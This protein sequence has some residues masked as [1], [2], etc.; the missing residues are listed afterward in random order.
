MLAGVSAMAMGIHLPS[1]PAI[2]HHFKV[3]ARLAQLTVAVF[4]WGNALLQIVIGPLSDRYGRRVILMWSSALFCLASLGCAYAPSI[5]VLLICR[6]AQAVIAGGLVLSRTIVRDMFAP[7]QA[8]SMIGYVTM[9]MA[10]VPM[11]APGLGGILQ[12]TFGWQGSFL[13]LF[14]AGALLFLLVWAD[15]GETN[16][17]NFSSFGAQFRAY[18]ELLSSWR[19]WGYAITAALS[20]GA[21]F[22]YLGGAPVVGADIFGMGPTTLGFALGAP[23]LGYIIGNWISGRYSVQ[24]GINRMVLIGTTLSALGLI[25]MAA[26]FMTGFG[27]VWVFFGLMPCVGLGNGMVIP[28][29]TSGMLS[30]RPHL[31]GTASGLGGALM[32][33]GG[34]AL[35]T[36]GAL[37]TST[38]ALPLILMMAAS[39]VLAVFVI[40][41]TLAREKKLATISKP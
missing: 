16:A 41:M 5:E 27:S 1:L 30:V 22:A 31:A 33:A 23:A 26:L 3:D 37:V 19:F 15:L 36:L 10:I 21:F 40:R 13:A 35:A 14:L 29:A 12:E 2:A 28:N 18:P 4:L 24:V 34:A 38:S 25:L 9:C 20:A 8:A 39:G 11:L 7:E 6:T 32:V 17:A